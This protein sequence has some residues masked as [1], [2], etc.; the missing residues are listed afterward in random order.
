VD[1]FDR[2]LGRLRWRLG[3]ERVVQFGVRG[4]IL[5]GVTLIA[6]SGASWITG[7]HE[8]AGWPAFAP[9]LGA[10]ALAV[11]RWPSR[12]RAALAADR[13]MALQERLTTAVELSRAGQSGPFDALQIRDAL[14]RASN[15]PGAWLA[16][17]ARARNEAFLAAGVATLGLA[18]LL[19]LPGAPRPMSLGTSPAPADRLV[20]AD[21]ADRALPEPDSTG[22]TQASSEPIRRARPDADLANRVRQEQAE[23]SALDTL[24]HALASVSAGQQAADAIQQGNFETARDQLQSLADQADQLSD[25]AKQQLARALQQAASSTTGSDRQLADREQKA[26]QALSRSSY[27]EQRQALRN[28]ADQVQRSGSLSVPADQL[29]RDAGRLQQQAGDGLPNQAGGNGAVS[30]PS[31]NQ[32]AT[33]GAGVGTGSDPSMTGDPSRLD[34]AGQQVQVPSKLGNG[35]GVRPPDGTE[36]QT[37]TTPSINNRSVSEVSTAQQTGQVAAEQNLVPGE[38]RPVIRGYFR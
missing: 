27:G 37:G 8:T 38:Q 4:A 17:D 29:A 22:V 13:R 11:G 32:P 33:T 2:L 15:N 24:A 20:P 28:L 16:L 36:E 12:R 14:Q 3:A 19:L 21:L 5:S 35:Q 25:T 18:S 9:I 1:E 10:V 23:R 31:G 7:N 6:L 34:I 26:A 30:S